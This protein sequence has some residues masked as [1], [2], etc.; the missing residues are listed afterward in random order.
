[1]IITNASPV[2]IF[3][4]GKSKIMSKASFG[5][6]FHSLFKFFLVTPSGY[7]LGMIKPFLSVARSSGGSLQA[8]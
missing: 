2:T 8:C 1:M 5:R 3:P 7:W 6:R 4:A